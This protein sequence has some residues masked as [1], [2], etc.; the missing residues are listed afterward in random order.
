MVFAV[1]VL[2]S[3]SS[4][5][6]AV[7]LPDRVVLAQQL[8]GPLPVRVRGAQ[9]RV[10]RHRG[11]HR[12]T[13]CERGSGWRPPFRS[14]TRSAPTDRQRVMAT[15]CSKCAARE[16]SSGNDR[17]PVVELDVPLAATGDHRLD[18]QRHPGPEPRPLT[19]RRRSSRTTGS[20]CISVPMPCPVYSRISPYCPAPS[21]DCSTACDMSPSRLP[22]TACAIPA[23]IA[24][25]HRRQASPGRRDRS[26]PPPA[27]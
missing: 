22:A 8:R 25:P 16:P 4:N 11:R 26:R 19:G 23:H 20:M 27:R 17:P 12:D 10:T 15:V 7:S 14:R 3:R 24:P 18:R 2:S 5:S 21:T 13:E 6:S 9:P 1:N